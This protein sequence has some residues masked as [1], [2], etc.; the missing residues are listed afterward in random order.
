MN[1]WRLAYIFSVHVFDKSILWIKLK[2]RRNECLHFSKVYAIFLSSWTLIWHI[3]V[4]WSPDTMCGSRNLLQVVVVVVVGGQPWRPEN[5]QNNI[6][7]VSNWFY[8]GGPVDLLQ[9]KL[10]FSKD[11]EGV[12]HFLHFGWGGGGSQMLISI[13]THTTFDFLGSWGVE[14]PIP[15][16]IRTWKNAVSILHNSMNYISLE[17]FF[18]LDFIY[19]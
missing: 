1:I 7:I 8:R 3:S 2:W 19:I 15:L 18:Y 5:S 12:Q 9:R 6:V 13:G 14:T 10:N 16:W 4:Y 11:P 17:S